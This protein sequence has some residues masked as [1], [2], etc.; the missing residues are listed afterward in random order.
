[1]NTTHRGKP[2]TKFSKFLLVATSVSAVLLGWF[3]GDV[4]TERSKATQGLS[5]LSD[6]SVVL[7]HTPVRTVAAR[8]EKRSDVAASDISRP[9]VLSSPRAGARVV[10][11]DSFYARDPEEWQGGLVPNSPKDMAECDSS[12]RCGIALACIDG[13]CGACQVDANCAT[14][15]RCVLDHCLL[16]ANVGCVRR[17]DCRIEELCLL[18]D[19]DSPGPRGNLEL[20]SKCWSRKQLPPLQPAI[21]PVTEVLPETEEHKAQR[22]HLVDADAMVR[23]LQENP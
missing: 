20:R 11:V 14:G 22:R 5:G 15:E 1:M 19:M 12:E 7:R 21:P 10:T 2:G 6:S 18:E 17:H 3:A 13:R 9:R 8:E 4:L 16:A 23:S